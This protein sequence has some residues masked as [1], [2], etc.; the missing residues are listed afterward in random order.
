MKPKR[1]GLFEAK[2]KLSELLDQVERGQVYVIT[3]RGRPVAELHALPWSKPLAFGCDAGR[4][5]IGPDF[6]AP[7]PDLE[8]YTG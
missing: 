6:E 3:R 7:I 1:I 2:T 8:E 4:I 5:V